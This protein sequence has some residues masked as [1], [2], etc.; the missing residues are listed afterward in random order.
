VL[1]CRFN[2]YEHAG[3]GHDCRFRA[4]RSVLRQMVC[5]EFCDE[6]FDGVQRALSTE[7]LQIAA[8]RGARLL[9]ERSFASGDELG[10]KR[11]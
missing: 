8:R 6:K 11:Q 5:E 1:A 4:L 9:L 3:E 7:A 10:R 2:G